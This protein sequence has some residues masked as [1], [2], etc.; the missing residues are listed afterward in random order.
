MFSDDLKIL[1]FINQWGGF[2]K[3]YLFSFT[4]NL[5]RITLFYCLIFGIIFYIFGFKIFLHFFNFQI[6]GVEIKKVAQYFS[7][8]LIILFSKL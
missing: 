1:E 3:A 2:E 5:I 8:V 7:M 6:R 4:L